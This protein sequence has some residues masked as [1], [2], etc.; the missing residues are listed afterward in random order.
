M[1][2]YRF[3]LKENNLPLVRR[4]YQK[5][6]LINTSEVCYFVSALTPTQNFG[7]LVDS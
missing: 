6:Y 2:T 1:F 3:F 4:Q 7:F 5:M